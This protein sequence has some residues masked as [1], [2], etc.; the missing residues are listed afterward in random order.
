MLKYL[1]YSSF[2]F[3]FR[4]I[5]IYVLLDFRNAYTKFDIIFHKY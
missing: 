1:N 3:N 5:Y 2:N 4:Y